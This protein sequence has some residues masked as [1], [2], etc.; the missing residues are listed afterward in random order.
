MDQVGTVERW[1][2]GNGGWVR[3]ECPPGARDARHSIPP[4]HLCFV[5][6]GTTIDR[7]DRLVPVDVFLCRPD[8]EPISAT[9]WQRVKFAGLERKANAPSR[10][11]AIRSRLG[12]PGPLLREAAGFYGTSFGTC[13]GEPVR[14]HW[15]ADML[16]SQITER[17]P[18]ADPPQTCRDWWGIVEEPEIDARLPLDRRGTD[19]FYDAVA[20]VY[21]QVV[22][23]G[24]NPA[25]VIAAANP[26]IDGKVSTVH[27][28]IR[29]ARKRGKLAPGRRGKAG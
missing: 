2:V 5:R 12:I 3:V 27:Y 6:F 10:A 21:R 11:G 24:L 9:A 20:C 1:S 7:P 26:E 15:A 4:G 18:S 29:Q 22:G 16:W 28:W 19:E 8:G 25:P 17:V 13:G 23:A 14:P